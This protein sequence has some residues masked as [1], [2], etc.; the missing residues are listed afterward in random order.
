MN[1]LEYS[2]GAVVVGSIVAIVTFIVTF[3]ISNFFI[4]PREHW[5]QSRYAILVLKLGMAASAAFFAFT[6]IVG[7]FSGTR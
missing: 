5:R 3:K 2:F 1:N 7:L 6:I 4:A